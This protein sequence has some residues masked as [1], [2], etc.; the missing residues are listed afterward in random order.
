MVAAGMP[1]AEVMKR[2]G[3]TQHATFARYVNPTTD[4][5]RQSATLLDSYNAQAGAQHT[6]AELV[7]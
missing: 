7:N 3:H 2:S 5:A 6:L 1:S 4:S